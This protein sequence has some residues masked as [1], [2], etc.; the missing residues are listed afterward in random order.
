V[1]CEPQEG[2]QEAFVEA[3]EAF[4]PDGFN[5]AFE[6]GRVLVRAPRNRGHVHDPGLDN[7]YG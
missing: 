3:T 6:V 7:V 1:R 4:N 5:E 2:G